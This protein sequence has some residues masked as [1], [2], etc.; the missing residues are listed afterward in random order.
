MVD[1]F[2][3]FSLAISEINRY[4]HR[5]TTVEM[6]PYGLK[7]A[8]CLYLLALAR[9]PEGLTAPKVGELC[10][11]DKADVSRTLTLLEK[12]GMVEREGAHYR[13][14]YRLTGQGMDAA[15][16]VRNRAALAVEIAGRALTDDTR[17]VFYDALDSITA[18]LRKLD[19][20]G[21]PKT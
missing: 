20:E 3:R 2:E 8:H 1:R 16:H 15:E 14:R 10:D 6:E 4:W 18:N 21:L 19:E 17:A 7:G 5:L 9:H 11:R 12:Q 13:A